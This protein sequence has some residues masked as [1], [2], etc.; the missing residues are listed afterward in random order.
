MR[1][2]EVSHMDNN[3]EWFFFQRKL[4]LKKYELW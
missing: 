4:D 3:C 2:G 1:G